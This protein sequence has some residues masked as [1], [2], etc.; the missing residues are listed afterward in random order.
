MERALLSAALD[1][2]LAVDFDFARKD[3]AS[4]VPKSAARM[5]PTSAAEGRVSTNAYVDERRFQRR[6]NAHTIQPGFSP[7]N[8]S[9]DAGL[10]LNDPPRLGKARRQAAGNV[11]TK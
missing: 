2:A 10:R 11:D 3:T 1:F 5:I 8:L 9:V 6:V 7:D 4:A